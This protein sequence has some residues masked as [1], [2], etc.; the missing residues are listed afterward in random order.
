MLYL[1]FT[2]WII[3]SL[4]E[5]V[6]EAFYWNLYPAYKFNIH[7]LFFLQRSLVLIII[8]AFN[9]PMVLA[10]ALIFS[11]LH[12]GSYYTTR[13]LLNKANYPKTWFDQS[14]TS[15]SWMTKLNSP[16]SRTLQAAMGM[17]IFILHVLNVF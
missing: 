16:A 9:I 13:H 4:F 8:T 11:F 7:T 5:G 6:R 10:C 1:A 3:Y 14:T 12:N 17:G 15:T 2:V